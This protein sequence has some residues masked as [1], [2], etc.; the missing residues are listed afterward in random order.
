MGKAV[1]SSEVYFVD[2]FCVVHREEE[3][4]KV[5]KNC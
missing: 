1:K 3:K 2:W 4:E 5:H